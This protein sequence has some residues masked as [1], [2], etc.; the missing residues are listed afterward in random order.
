MSLVED[1]NNKK[2]LAAQIQDLG[3]QIADLEARRGELKQRLLRVDHI[4]VV[5]PNGIALSHTMEDIG[6]DFL[7]T[8]AISIHEEGR[9]RYA[10]CYYNRNY[11]SMDADC[12]PWM[13]TLR[14]RTT[15]SVEFQVN[16]TV[17]RTVGYSKTLTQEGARSIALSW[18]L[19]GLLPLLRGL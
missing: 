7:T 4:K 5:T 11:E 19:E 6:N 14:E 15:G 16:P 2:T 9:V 18:L 10:Q 13:V 1:F 17:G 3:D 8:S 12:R